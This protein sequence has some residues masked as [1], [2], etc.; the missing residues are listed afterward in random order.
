MEENETLVPVYSVSR[1]FAVT[2]CVFVS[3][4]VRYDGAWF[5]FPFLL[6]VQWITAL[7]VLMH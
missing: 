2:S 3:G 7:R 1:H 6:R 4:E 5:H